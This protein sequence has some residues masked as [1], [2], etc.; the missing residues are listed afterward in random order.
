MTNS[1]VPQS[2][3]DNP[4]STWTLL[5]HLVSIGWPITIGIAAM[6]GLGVTDTLMVGLVSTHDLA[7]LGVGANVYFI[8]T[9]M[10]IGLLSV[11]APRVAWRLALGVTERVR[12]D[13]WQ[14]GWLGLSAGV[15][16][17][18]VMLLSVSAFGLLQ[19]EPD[20]QAVAAR[21]ASTVAFTLPLIGVNLVLRATLDGF[22][23][24]RLSMI[25]SLSI[26]FLNIL[27]DYALVFG[28]FGLPQLGAQ[29]CAY[30]TC[31]VIAVQTLL[32]C[33]FIQWHR[34]M[35]DYRIF[36]RLIRP[37]WIMIKPLLWLGVPAAL[38]VT[39]EESFF[40]ASGVLVAPM[41][42]APLAAHQIVLSVALTA[43]VV[44]IGL[45][46]AGAIVVGA[47]LGADRADVAR[48]QALALLM[49]IGVAG[50]LFAVLLFALR[51]PLMSLFTQDAAVIAIG[52][53][54]LAVCSLQMLV[55]SM[56]L[57]SN[58]TLKGYQDTMVPAL[59]QIFSYWCVGFPLAWVLSHTQWLGGPWGVPGV[60]LGIAGA[61]AVSATLGALRL[62]IVSAQFASGVRR[63]PEVSTG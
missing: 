24:T 3:I 20:V 8:F 28:R 41:G 47:S 31:T 26:F 9:M 62:N 11:I 44:P 63:L 58:I 21:Y 56:Q 37:R 55:D 6:I 61:L 23:Y 33:S 43:L 15:V 52:L 14:S 46:Q 39:F 49:V 2:V 36:E 48:R 51:L 57:G 17:G 53:P 42:T 30:A 32:S 5:R 54:V 27:L 38:A 19:L 1:H 16:V 7:A 25:I 35:R 18:I 34:R 60:W 22:G 10:L 45:G 59:L 50:L 29:G 12:E 13:V 40:A 4:Q